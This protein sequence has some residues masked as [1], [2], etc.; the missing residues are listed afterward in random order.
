M[1]ARLLKPDAETAVSKS[2]WTFWLARRA[3][4]AF[5][6]LRAALQEC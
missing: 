6:H 4:D 5:E 3:S 1:T 2:R